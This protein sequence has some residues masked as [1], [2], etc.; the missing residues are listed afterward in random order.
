[1]SIAQIEQH[2][3]DLVKAKFEKRLKT[4]ESLPADW[5]ADTFRRL[6]RLTPGVFVVF[7]GGQRKDTETDEGKVVIDG[8][9][10]LIAATTHASG[11][12][13]RRHGDSQ[14]IGAYEIVERLCDLLEGHEVPGQGAM[15]FAG[16]D[17]LFT[18]DLEKQGAAIY[19]VQFVLP[20]YVSAEGDGGPVLDEF[21]TFHGDIDMAPQDGHV[22]AADTVHL[23]Q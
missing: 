11:E 9:W 16:I 13:A 19:G 3:I 8:Q 7:G 6:L 4:V 12:L 1:M 10:G 2:L 17:N 18:G 22:D 15:R 23:E 21:K 14:E 20:M 5:D